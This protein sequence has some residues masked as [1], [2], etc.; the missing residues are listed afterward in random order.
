[1]LR[2]DRKSRRLNRLAVRNSR[3]QGFTG[4]HLATILHL[5]AVAVDEQGAAESPKDRLPWLVQGVNRRRLVSLF[6]YTIQVPMLSVTYIRAQAGDEVRHSGHLRMGLYTDWPL[7][8]REINYNLGSKPASPCGVL[9]MVDHVRR[10]FRQPPY[11]CDLASAPSPSI[12][13]PS[14]Q[15]Q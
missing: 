15:Q 1:M 7:E 6:I 9:L 11:L 8:T 5:T 12:L 3:R 14:R 10:H 4:A 2:L 13:P